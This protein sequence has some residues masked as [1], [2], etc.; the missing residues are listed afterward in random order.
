MG[1]RTPGFSPQWGRVLG[2]PMPGLF[3]SSGRGAGAGS[4]GA[5][6]LSQLR[7]GRGLGRLEQGWSRG[8]GAGS[9]DTWVLSLGRAWVTPGSR[10]KGVGRGKKEAGWTPLFSTPPPRYNACRDDLTC[11]QDWVRDWRWGPEGNNCTGGCAPY[12]QVRGD[13]VGGRGRL[14]PGPLMSLAYCP[15]PPPP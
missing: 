10:G 12:S 14:R 5:W 15:A 3:P 4:S 7:E 6:G 8:G 9:P 13:G 1:G 11:A 2:T